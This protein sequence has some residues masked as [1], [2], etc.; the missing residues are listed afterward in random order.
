MLTSMEKSIQKKGSQ[1]VYNDLRKQANEVFGAL[2]FPSC[3][4][5]SS[6]YTMQRQS[7]SITEDE[8][9]GLLKYA[10]DK[11]ELVVNHSDYLKDVWV[12]GTAN[13]CAD[14]AKFTTS[15]LR[16]NTENK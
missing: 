12:L 13:M 2:S 10:R 9:Q 14:L 15:D 1:G 11:E 6:R 4:E 7:S 16:S 3:L 8:V 5:E